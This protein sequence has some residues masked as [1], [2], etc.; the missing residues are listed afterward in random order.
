MPTTP[1]A[2]TPLLFLDNPSMRLDRGPYGIR[3]FVNNHFCLLCGLRP[4]RD[5]ED[6]KPDDEDIHDSSSIPL[7]YATLSDGFLLTE[8]AYKGIPASYQQYF[9]KPCWELHAQYLAQAIKYASQHCKA[10][11]SSNGKSKKRGPSA[12]KA[13]IQDVDN[14]TQSCISSTAAKRI[15]GHA[16]F[17]GAILGMYNWS[18]GVMGR[19]ADLMRRTLRCQST[20]GATWLWMSQRS[21]VTAAETRDK[22]KGALETL[23]PDVAESPTWENLKEASVSLKK[24][25]DLVKLTGGE[26]DKSIGKLEKLFEDVW[27]ALGYLSAK[28]CRIKA[29]KKAMLMTKDEMDWAYTNYV[30]LHFPPQKE[31]EELTENLANA[32]SLEE[33]VNANLLAGWKGPILHSIHKQRVQVP[34]ASAGGGCGT[35]QRD[36][37]Q[38]TGQTGLSNASLQQSWAGENGR[39]YWDAL[40]ASSP[41]RTSATRL[42]VDT[43]AYQVR[44]RILCWA[45]KDILAS[46]HYPDAQVSVHSMELA[47]STLHRPWAFR[48]IDY[49]KKGSDRTSYF[50]QGGDYDRLVAKATFPHCVVFLSTFTSIGTKAGNVLFRVSTG[51]A[52]REPRFRGQPLTIVTSNAPNCT[53]FA[54]EFLYLAC[55]ELHQLCNATTCQDGVTKLS[56]NS[57]VRTGATALPVFNGAKDAIAAQLYC[58]SQLK[59]WKSQQLELTGV[60]G[61]TWDSNKDKQQVQQEIANR[62]LKE[63]D[64]QGLQGEMLLSW[65]SFLMDYKHVLFHPLMRAETNA[66]LEPFWEQWTLKNLQSRASSKLLATLSILEHYKDPAA[67]PLFFNRDGTCNVK[68]ESSLCLLLPFK[69]QPSHKK[70]SFLSCTT[71]TPKSPNFLPLQMLDLH[72]Y[73]Y[74]EYNGS[75]TNI[76]RDQA[77]KNFESQDDVYIM[78]LSNVGTTGLN[79]TMALVI[80]FLLLAPNTA[81][82]ILSLYATS[83]TIMENRF[84]SQTKELAT[85]IFQYKD[86]TDSEA[87]K[88]EAPTSYSCSAVVPCA[89]KSQEG[90]T[91]STQPT[92]KKAGKPKRAK[93][94]DK[95]KAKNAAQPEPLPSEHWLSSPAQG[96][97]TSFPKGKVNPGATNGS[98]KSAETAS[99]EPQSPPQSRPQPQPRPRMRISPN[100]E[101][102]GAIANIVSP[103]LQA[104]TSAPLTTAAGLANLPLVSFAPESSPEVSSIAAVRV[105]VLHD[106]PTQQPSFAPSPDSAQPSTSQDL[107]AVDSSAPTAAQT[108]CEDHNHSPEPLVG[109]GSSDIS[110]VT[111]GGSVADS[112]RSTGPTLGGPLSL[113]SSPV[114][115]QGSGSDGR[116]V[117]Q[118]N[119]YPHGESLLDAF[120]HELLNDLDQSPG[121][122]TKLNPPQAKDKATA[123]DTRAPAPYHPTPAR[124]WRTSTTSRSSAK[125]TPYDHLKATAVLPSV[126]DSA[127]LFLT[128]P[129]NLP[130]ASYLMV[131]LKQPAPPQRPMVRLGAFKDVSK[132]DVP[133][134]L[135][136][137][138]Q[139]VMDKVDRV[140]QTG[141][142]GVLKSQ[143]R[144]MMAVNSASIQVVPLLENPSSSEKPTSRL[145]RLGS[146]SNPPS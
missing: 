110:A 91:T 145:S 99:S 12:R 136:K 134:V 5:A 79:L 41:H 123:V 40:H 10:A 36:V 139:A 119:P 24:Y 30:E 116:A 9:T 22:C 97:Q 90:D 71:A 4:I 140:S 106:P 19:M 57:L 98:S 61:A 37:Y 135:A 7:E 131:P 72:K 1:L 70:F 26:M 144:R 39:D 127:M 95:D 51:A 114:L 88:N 45:R 75:M 52:G 120:V 35:A 28:V 124:T 96:A 92:I 105:P 32:V 138:K 129:P 59:E 118:E 112:L 42:S 60:A 132:E 146:K 109:Q 2:H 25:K 86:K 55:N 23:T 44:A 130:Q 69:L 107:P 141:G 46:F 76:E 133:K 115:P 8:E 82:K 89:L 80:I 6:A 65:N 17:K 16:Q 53:I 125:L 137:G 85:K 81:N 108:A 58:R 111:Q 20:R 64:P 29:T 77:M 31:G 21:L 128:R 84:F 87:S 62:F 143:Q 34:M 43:I 66:W 104:E 11:S 33:G 142:V 13:A 126:H 78:L 14:I 102:G 50:S 56:C 121:S 47:V 54:K 101:D 38:A 103:M 73:K 67:E 83:K 74:V 18:N 27:V 113:K 93:I 122:P 68:Q 100:V 3:P 48:L 94:L 15:S 49:A 117:L 63:G